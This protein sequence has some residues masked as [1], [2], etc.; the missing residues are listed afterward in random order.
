MALKWTRT[1]KGTKQLLRVWCCIKAGH[2]SMCTDETF[3]IT[4]MFRNIMECS[5]LLLICFLGRSLIRSHYLLI[6]FVPLVKHRWKQSWHLR[7]YSYTKG[8]QWWCE[9]SF[10]CVLGALSAKCSCI[11]DA[12]DKTVVMVIIMENASLVVCFGNLLIQMCCYSICT[13]LKQWMV[14]HIMPAN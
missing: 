4:Q 6:T 9:Y 1:W 11:Q 10:I 5:W 13:C 14:V 8:K 2:H 12:F 7:C 3:R